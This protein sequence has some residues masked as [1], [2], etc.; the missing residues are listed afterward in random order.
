MVNGASEMH[1][2]VSGDAS[3]MVQRAKR[4]RREKSVSDTIMIAFHA[5]CDLRDFEIAKRLLEIFENAI[6][7]ASVTPG[8]DRRR[9]LGV[10][11]AGHERL[12]H[13]R[14]H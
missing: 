8:F 11:V 3:E 10:L 4:Q 1:Y 6:L 12:W 9:A 14:H 7:A 5:A 13:L 2:E